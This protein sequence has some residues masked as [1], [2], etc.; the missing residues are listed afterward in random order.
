[1]KRGNFVDSLSASVL[2]E[3]PVSSV[4]VA[5]QLFD[6]ASKIWVDSS[7]VMAGHAHVLVIQL[8]AASIITS[9]VTRPDDGK[10]VKCDDLT[11]M[12]GCTAETPD[13]PAHLTHSIDDWWKNINCV[14]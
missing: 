4:A 1:M 14:S 11:A 13:S 2:F 12:S 9:L 7:D 10:L 5:K 8:M 6:N 3:G